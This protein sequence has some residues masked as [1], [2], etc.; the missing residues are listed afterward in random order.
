MAKPRTHYICRSCGGVQA[1]WMGKCPDCGTWDALEKF[2]ETKPEKDS[3]SGLAESWVGGAEAG[4]G[5]GR[6]AA[7]SVASAATSTG[8]TSL[9]S[10]LPLPDIATSDVARLPTGLGQLHRVL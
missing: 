10:A 1:R 4:A 6:G 3:H 9:A 2:I 8:I 5:L 7:T